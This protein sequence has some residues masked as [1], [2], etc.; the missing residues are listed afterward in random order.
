MIARAEALIYG[1]EIEAGQPLA[2]EAA[3]LS[4]EQGHHRRLERIQS[5]KQYL[6]RQAFRFGKAEKGLDEALSGPTER[7]SAWQ[8]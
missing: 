3:K 1:G 7:W 8:S 2:V 5:I 4:R 6:N